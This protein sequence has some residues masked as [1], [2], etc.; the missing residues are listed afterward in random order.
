MIWRKLQ[1]IQNSDPEAMAVEIQAQIAAADALSGAGMAKLQ[2]TLD[3]YGI[4]LDADD[5]Y[6]G[7]PRV[8]GRITGLR[9]RAGAVRDEDDGAATKYVYLRVEW[10]GQPEPTGY[11]IDCGYENRSF[12]L[13]D[14]YPTAFRLGAGIDAVVTPQG[15]ALQT[16]YSSRPDKAPATGL[17]GGAD[18]RDSG[19][20]KWPLVL[21]TIVSWEKATK[22][23]ITTSKRNITVRLPDGTLA[24]TKAS[25]IPAHVH[26]YVVPGAEIPVGLNPK[27][28]GEAAIDWIT[29]A[30]RRAEA[31]EAGHSTDA[32]PAGSLAAESAGPGGVGLSTSMGVTTVLDESAPIDIPDDIEGLTFERYVKIDSYLTMFRV[33]KADH[34]RFA[35]V[36]FGVAPGRYSAIA[37]QWQQRMRS[38]TRLYEI[39]AEL[40]DTYE[41]VARQA[42]MDNG[43]TWRERGDL[44]R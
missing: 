14:R 12:D 28:P 38:D 11:R 36:E 23:G 33:D 8:T 40:R 42:S 39:L 29:L 34:D 21:G 25:R 35:T 15:S 9:Y 6:L 24:T 26:F 2:A 19:S 22:L 4:D 1:G 37:E 43:W 10:P 3:K 13:S 31:G 20:E 16:G 5:P 17:S 18:V 7:A 44:D 27:N 41:P 30:H 32:V